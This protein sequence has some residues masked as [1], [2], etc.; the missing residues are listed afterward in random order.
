MRPRLAR[1]STEAT[2]ARIRGTHPYVFRSGQW[3]R[4]VGTVDD[5]ETGRCCY[6]VVFEEDGAT[7]FWPVDDTAA[8][9][10]LA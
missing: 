7:D 5:P 3:A 8:G 9:Y 2:P 10:E 1:V 4:L 6:S